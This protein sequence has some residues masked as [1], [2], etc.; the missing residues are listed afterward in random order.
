MN[1]TI[2]H[3]DARE[4]LES[5]DVIK[6]ASFVASMPDY[7]EFPTLSLCEWKKWFIDMARLIIAKTDENEAAIFYQSDIKYEGEWIDKSFLCQQAAE[8]EG[9][10]L[11]WHKIICRVP[12]GMTTFG[13]PS[14]AHI[15]CFS[16]KLKVNLEHSTP[17]VIPLLGEKLWER[18]MSP[19]ACVLI[20]QFIKKE[21]TS[22]TV[23]NPFCGM[24]S[25]PSV[26]NAFMLSAIGI[27]KSLKRVKA[28]EKIQFDLEKMKW[29][30]F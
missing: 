2:Y 7:S 16:K 14:Y 10:R 18:G 27:E 20:A 30:K 15:L 11:L 23:I 21:T 6:K 3:Q 5:I 17:D 1:R 8:I 19:H 9:A 4:W 25:M 29:K 24:G 12:A 13:R 22:V 26:A 28:A